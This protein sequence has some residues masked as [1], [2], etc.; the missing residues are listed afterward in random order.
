MS[1]ILFNILMEKLQSTYLGRGVTLLC[2]ADDLQL[3]IQGAPI[4]TKTALK[5]LEHACQSLGL[6]INA[7]K[8]KCMAIGHKT[9]PNLDLQIQGQKLTWT[10]SHQV[11]GVY[12][13]HR[14]DMGLQVSYLRER[15][16]TRT[17]VLR[18][19]T[20]YPSGADYEVLR[21]YYTHAIRSLIDYCAPALITLSDTQY[22]KIEV[23][24]NNAMRTMLGAPRWTKIRNMQVE[25]RLDPLHTRITKLA[26]TCT[27]RLTRHNEE[28]IAI[29]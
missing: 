7:G 20:S 14:L 5:A 19:L 16:K 26:A 11:L 1:V 17:N 23:I 15:S 21:L 18:T 3:V 4:K 12:I 24:Q 28:V 2:Y 6:K 10:T 27:L 9:P 22:Q 25:T 8:T 13:D 29:R